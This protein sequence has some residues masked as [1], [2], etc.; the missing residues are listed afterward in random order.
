MSRTPDKGTGSSTAQARAADPAASA[1]VAAN[2]GTGKTHVLVERVLRLLL[3]GSAPDRILCLTY[4]KAAAAEMSARLFAKLA[5]WATVADGELR[6]Q[7]R[8]TLGRAPSPPEATRA[9]TLFA[10]AIE[11]PGG[12]KVETI[13]AFAQR[14]L[15]RF[16]LEAAVAPGFAVLDE[17]ERRALLAD[18]IGATLARA[19]AAPDGLL[20]GALRRVAARA[21]EARFDELMAGATGFSREIDELITSASD[22]GDPFLAIRQDL[23]TRLRVPAG[24]TLD[25]VEAELAG[26]L[27]D[28]EMRG[29]V[30]ALAEGS[31]SDQGIADQ[32][33]SM[34]ATSNPEARIEALASVFLTDRGTPRKTVMTKSVRSRNAPLAACLDRAR[35]RFL[36][37]HLAWKALR[38]VESSVDL[39]RLA[40][41]VLE[42]Y[43][44]RKAGQAA[45]DFD[46]LIAATGRLIAGGAGARWVLFKLD[47]G[48]EHILVDEA[49]DTA[50]AQW[51]IVS[52][53]AAEFH[54]GLGTSEALRTVFAV[55]DEKQSIYGFQG[56]APAMFAEMERLFSGRATSAGQP[57]NSV[58]L[59]MSFRS[60][61]PVL[62]AVDLVFGDAQ[63]TPGLTSMPTAIRHEPFRT[64]AGGL[65]ELWPTEL[66]DEG[67]EA[68][69]F[70]PLEDRGETSP[71]QRLA[72]RIAERIEAM[73]RG[74]RLES[75]GRPI[76]AGDILV[77]VRRRRPFAPA[78]I[79]A[80]RDLQIPAAGADRI[81]VTESLAVED[82]VAL[83]RFML[84]PEDDLSLAG[85]LKSPLIGLDDDDLISIAPMRRGS[86]WSALLDSEEAGGRLG[87]AAAT[88]KRWRARADFLPPFELYSTILEREGRRALMLGR[89][90]AEAGDAI[91][92]FLNLA[93]RYDEAH[94]PSLQGFLDW[95][96]GASPEIR[97]DMDQGRDEVRVMTVHG[98]K[99]LEAPI[100]FLADT[101]STRSAQKG[102]TLMRLEVEEG[103]TPPTAQLVWRVKDAGRLEP[104]AEAIAAEKSRERHEYHR[105]LY[106]AMTRA[107][108]RLYVAGFEGRKGRDA[109]CWYDLIADGLDSH[110]REAALPDGTSV[111]RLEKRH[112]GEHEKPKVT[113]GASEAA[114]ELPDWARRRA[115]REDARTI[116][117][118][119]SRLAPLESE[120][121]AL[122]AP[123]EPSTYAP[124]TLAAG[125]RFL[126][127][128]LTH[129][130][131]Q[132][133]PE[134]PPEARAEAGRRFLAAPAHGISSALAADILKEALAVLEDERFAAVFATG[135]VAEVPIAA[136]IPLGSGPPLSLTGQID[137]LA[138][139]A[140]EV[141]IVDY[142][143]NRPPPARIEDVADAYLLQLAAYALALGRIHPGKE[144]AAAL[145]WT[146][147]PRLMGI[148]KPM[149][150]AAGRRLLAGEP[151]AA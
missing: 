12:L 134:L 98:A 19:V 79:R 8:R 78:L 39:L 31:A 32:L 126:R 63:R 103:R 125:N 43:A 146:D 57:F 13:H 137:R 142:K 4:T 140:S 96:G 122:P 117:V 2:A 45:L 82:L 151:W 1:W 76:R 29:L 15:Q 71:M 3:S 53:L 128:T 25:H 107:R 129:A 27:C 50:P 99:G 58:P 38:L 115:P 138:V 143:T 145:L 132:H 52:E 67:E 102:G 17:E 144:I 149:L 147:G 148:P 51:R 33:R 130:L 87:G 55:G 70:A 40:D 7:L 139:T 49:Q 83:G 66:P 105:L 133:L 81:R 56:A 34:A 48:L 91:D 47:E 64:R 42:G 116:P 69:P 62:Q 44:E 68:D 123:S 37:H 95:L 97:R 77:L 136:E 24:T 72:V 109:G 73:L 75:E 61:A 22:E 65:D 127:G 21:G 6:E 121:P 101:C 5:G 23:M 26:L 30:A 80:L 84:L 74:E 104:V 28:D 10:I 106:V 20:A 93:I 118:A 131:L 59:T 114:A 111:R 14:L 86:L 110:A 108:D 124:R 46:D 90:G 89:L 141:L 36:D 18:A 94:P 120:E 112:E 113:L 119:P 35:D 16:P 41:D 150:E 9:R 54:A 135:S 11:T 88:L 92:E 85:V 100:V 60:A